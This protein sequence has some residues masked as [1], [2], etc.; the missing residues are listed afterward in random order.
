MQILHCR[1]TW[2]TNKFAKLGNTKQHTKLVCTKILPVRERS[3]DRILL[4]WPASV[5]CKQEQLAGETRP[6][7]L[8]KRTPERVCSHAFLASAVCQGYCA[9]C[10]WCTRLL[11]LPR[12][13]LRLSHTH[14]SVWMSVRSA[15]FAGAFWDGNGCDGRCALRQ[16]VVAAGNSS[17]LG[18]AWLQ[19]RP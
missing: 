4:C 7:V 8:C 15:C 16:A 3:Q 17:I 1:A 10:S 13:L 11:A 12:E 14:A 19:V 6:C 9:T 2:I 5:E 18:R